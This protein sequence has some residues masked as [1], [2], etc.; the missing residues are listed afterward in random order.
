[1][2]DGQSVPEFA[3]IL[4][5][6]ITNGRLPSILLVGVDS[7]GGSFSNPLED[8]RAQEYLPSDNFNPARFAAHEG[9]FIDEVRT[10]AE[11]ELAA[12]TDRQQRAIFGFSN[13][14]VFAAAMGIRHP[15]IYGHTLAFSLGIEPG[16]VT[17]VMKGASEFY[18]VAGTLEEG[19]HSTTE[20]FAQM[21]ELQGVTYVFR[22][23]VCGHDHIMWQEEFPA[24]V[25][26]AFG[27]R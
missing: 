24:A 16:R 5:P 13:G 11:R 8:R 7:P 20:E 3:A 19:F 17:E 10:W 2:A 27:R 18:L 26:W 15:D 12:P 22:E 1:M 14:G 9:F 4:E 6:L 25:E 23:R 21:L